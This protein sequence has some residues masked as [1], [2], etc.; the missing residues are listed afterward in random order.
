MSK[1]EMIAIAQKRYSNRH[2]SYEQMT[3]YIGFVKGLEYAQQE[4]ASLRAEVEFWKKEA[5]AIL[6]SYNSLDDYS[7]K[8]EK[9]IEKLETEISELEEEA[10]QGR[11]AESQ[12][13]IADEEIKR[14]K[15]LIEKLWR[16]IE[17]K[18]LVYAGV[19][20]DEET[21]NE[22]DKYLDTFKQEN[23]L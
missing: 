21:F 10:R 22:M 19:A 20:P 15:G 9:E 17:R 13:I 11:I 12:L 5:D 14:L 23:N 7:S 8:R 3:E 16:E 2:L 4:T 1:E 6:A 18:D